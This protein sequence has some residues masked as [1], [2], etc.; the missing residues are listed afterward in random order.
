VG[1]RR[2]LG[3]RI[4]ACGAGRAAGLGG[5]GEALLVRPP[6][7]ASRAAQKAGGSGSRRLA[8]AC[9]AKPM[10]H[11]RGGR[12]RTQLRVQRCEEAARAQRGGRGGGWGEGR[13]GAIPIACQALIMCIY[14]IICL[15]FSRG[16]PLPTNQTKE[17]NR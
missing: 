14:R 1:R 8:R 2:S 5:E 17:E 13:I 16:Q 10:V 11:S 9:S 15:G 3:P 12:M 7:V 4:L 6:S